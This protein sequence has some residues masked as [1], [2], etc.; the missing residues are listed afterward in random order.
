MFAG[1]DYSEDD[2][3]CLEKEDL[4]KIYIDERGK[5]LLKGKNAPKN[6]G[7]I[8]EVISKW[9]EATQEDITAFF[10]GVKTKKE[11]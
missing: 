9:K 10:K 8:G 2:S 6:H 11:E 7:S 4:E 5:H 1:K 3:P